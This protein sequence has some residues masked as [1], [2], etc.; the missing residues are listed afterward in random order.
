MTNLRKKLVFIFS[1]TICATQPAYGMDM[2]TLYNTLNSIKGLPSAVWNNQTYRKAL[3]AYLTLCI[4]REAYNQYYKKNSN[5]LEKTLYTPLRGTLV[6]PVKLPAD[7]A[8]SCIK[9]SWNLI[10]RNPDPTSFLLYIPATLGS[11]ILSS[12]VT[13]QIIN[14][15]VFTK[16][17]GS[18][19]QTDLSKP[20]I[21]APIKQEWMRT[22]FG[23]LDS[24]FK[25]IGHSIL[26]NTFLGDPEERARN[27]MKGETDNKSRLTE[28]GSHEHIFHGTLD[29]QLKEVAENLKN[30]LTSPMASNFIVLYGPPGTGKTA[31]AVQTARES[32]ATKV[33]L[34]NAIESNDRYINGTAANLNVALKEFNE[35]AK[36]DP[37]NI[38]ALVFDEAD[39]GTNKR[40]KADVGSVDNSKTTSTFMK[41]MNITQNLKNALF[42]ATT[43]RLEDM[44]MAIL[45][46]CDKKICLKNSTLD[47]NKRDI[48]KG[49]FKHCKCVIQDDVIDHIMEHTNGLPT[50]TLKKITENICVHAR[51]HT[52]SRITFKNI[53][54]I[55]N[56][57]VEYVYNYINEYNHNMRTSQNEDDHEDIKN[58]KLGLSKLQKKSFEKEVQSKVEMLKQAFTDN[59][60]SDQILKLIDECRKLLQKQYDTLEKTPEQKLLHTIIET[61]EKADLKTAQT[62]LTKFDSTKS[63]FETSLSKQIDA[64]TKIIKNLELLKKAKGNQASLV[65]A[66]RLREQLTQFKSMCTYYN[67][68]TKIYNNKDFFEEVA[69]ERNQ[70]SVITDTLASIKTQTITSELIQQ[71]CAIKNAK[72]TLQ[73]Y[74]QNQAETLVKSIHHND[75]KLIQ[76]EC[77]NLANV[78]LTFDQLK[79]QTLMDGLDPVKQEKDLTAKDIEKLFKEFESKKL[80]EKVLGSSEDDLETV[81]ELF[82]DDHSETTLKIVKEDVTKPET[83]TKPKIETVIT[84]KSSVKNDD[85]E[86]GKIIENA[87]KL[88]E[89]TKHK[90]ENVQALLT[91]MQ[92]KY[93][94]YEPK[95]KNIYTKNFKPFKQATKAQLRPSSWFSY[96]PLISHFYVKEKV[97][98]KERNIGYIAAF[99]NQLFTSSPSSKTEEQTVA[100]QS[101]VTIAQVLHEAKPEVAKKQ[102][103]TLVAGYQNKDDDIIKFVQEA[104]PEKTDAI[105]LLN[106]K[107]K[108]LS[109]KNEKNEE[110][111]D[112]DWSEPYELLTGKKHTFSPDNSVKMF[113]THSTDVKP[114]KDADKILTSLKTFDKIRNF[115]VMGSV[116]APNLKVV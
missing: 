114:V 53:D 59:K 84:K 115:N 74:L 19:T 31:S 65:L 7:I 43:N 6:Q 39:D 13:S 10:Q 105:K 106:T 100:P 54:A 75:I 68:N 81:V 38:Y 50:R 101:L 111:K 51:T 72:Q 87:Q 47:A 45:N 112:E 73:G 71:F 66:G 94:T 93:E 28:V 62:E 44:D 30:P 113:Y 4:A 3:Y 27:L 37:D 70:S 109:V 97:T 55:N 25:Q 22:L 5:P 69:A 78:V 77:K 29:A 99:L 34:Y 35:L 85:I 108:L 86:G 102:L 32:G 89:E 12:L 33:F 11:G 40:N 56:I 18:L 57:I 90:I 48:L 63:P 83:I 76:K 46:R 67:S 49:T 95:F 82:E 80:P 88:S 42:I 17:F 8:K 2:T 24:M 91:I 1:I 14:S 23:P 16:I 116:A 52:N 104:N 92:N 79:L 26:R 107:T 61:L 110:F 60:N 21:L 64:L 98:P 9:Y 15:P 20:E 96:V 58:L 41:E 36:N 103:C